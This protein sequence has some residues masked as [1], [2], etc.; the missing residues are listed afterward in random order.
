MKL[1]ILCVLAL[2]LQGCPPAVLPIAATTGV[3]AVKYKWHRDEVLRTEAFR[4]AVLDGFTEINKKLE[5]SIE[6][7]SMLSGDDS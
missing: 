2:S 6:M 1:L 7:R 5:D 3:A 4:E